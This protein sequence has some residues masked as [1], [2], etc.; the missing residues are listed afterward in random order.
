[1]CVSESR[2]GKMKILLYMHGA[3]ASKYLT[4]SEVHL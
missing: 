3:T 4:E 2:V 1:M